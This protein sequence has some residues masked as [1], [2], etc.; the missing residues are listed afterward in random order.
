MVGLLETGKD[1]LLILI[2]FCKINTYY[3]ICTLQLL[4]FGMCWK[5]V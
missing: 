5:C 3:K 2:C 1:L 4:E